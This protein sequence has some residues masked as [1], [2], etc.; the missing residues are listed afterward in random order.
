[1]SYSHFLVSSLFT[2]TVEDN[3]VTFVEDDGSPK[4]AQKGDHPWW[5]GDLPVSQKVYELATKIKRAM[6]WVEFGVVMDYGYIRKH[7]EPNTCGIAFDELFVYTPGQQYVMGRIG[8]RDYGVR[9]TVFAYGVSSRKI[10]IGKVDRHSDRSHTAISKDVSRAVKHAVK[11]L[12]P[13]TT[14][15]CAKLSFGSFR[16][17]VDAEVS[18]TVASADKLIGACRAASVL[19]AEITNLIRQN[20]EFVTP[21]FKAAATHYL[22]AQHEAVVT[23]AKKIGGY[24]VH[25]F[26]AHDKQFAR[27]AVTR[28]SIKG[29]ITPTFESTDDLV[30]PAED[31]PFDTQA[32]LAVLMSLDNESYV[33]E[34]GYRVDSTT[35]WVERELA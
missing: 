12:I 4:K 25:L 10:K 6:P 5:I 31:I 1:M 15:E 11:N 28:G 22:A 21:E 3:I 16:D 32:K 20:V 9:D 23:K 24:F 2:P 7:Y 8:H 18:Q 19:T 27:V 29:V 33:T 14:I 17:H 30:I 26:T 34:V 35:F 13:Y